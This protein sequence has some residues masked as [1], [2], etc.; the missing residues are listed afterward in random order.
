MQKRRVVVTGLG[1]I[2][3]IGTSIRSFWEHIVQGK[4][5]VKDIQNVDCSEL[6]FNKGVEVADYDP[7]DF[8][9]IRERRWMDRFAQFGLLAAEQAIMDSRIEWTDALRSKTCIVTGSGIG[10]QITH[11]HT[12]SQLYR[13][14]KKGIHPLTIPRIM[15]NGATSAISIRYGITGPAFTTSTACAS[16]NHAIGHAFWMIRNGLC[17][18]AVTGGS[19]TPL[20]YGFLKAWEAI[21]IVAPDTCRPFSKDRKGLI[22]GE[23]SG[24]LILENYDH[25]LKRSAPIYAELIGFG[26][27]ADASHITMPNVDGA[28]LSMENALRDAGIETKEIDYINAHGT[29]TKAN[30]V[31]ETRAIRTL[32]GDQADRLAVSSTKSMHGHALGGTGSLEAIATV[33]ALQNDV[34]PPTIN[35]REPDP[36]CDLDV[37]PNVSRPGTIRYALSNAFAFGGLNAVLAFKKWNDIT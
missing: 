29:G 12:F 8:F 6:N 33:L 34:L 22:L 9:D 20:S 30:D 19:E 1:V 37:V 16:S 28:V 25:A 10:G 23:G 31:M 4:S 35:Y 18:L 7:A 27:S 15:P 32:F 5:G 24:M 11:D 36:E 14:G 17:D 13:E 3:G 2:S 26:M 21:R